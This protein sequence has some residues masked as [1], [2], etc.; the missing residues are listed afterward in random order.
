MNCWRLV[1]LHGGEPKD[2]HF[3]LKPPQWKVT[4][5]EENNGAMSLWWYT[6]LS[7]S[8]YI[9]RDDI[10]N[11]TYRW[12]RWYDAM[13]QCIP[14]YVIYFILCILHVK[15]SLILCKN[16]WYTLIHLVRRRYSDMYYPLNDTTYTC[17]F[18]MLYQLLLGNVG[19]VLAA[20]GCQQIFKSSNYKNRNIDGNRHPSGD[21]T[22]DL[23]PWGLHW[24]GICQ[25]LKLP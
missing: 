11:I 25:L 9:L 10:W 24:L 7:F 21:N 2:E 8:I 20:M 5:R 22:P 14:L 12:Y 19:R 13:I 4:C 6:S 17:C 16:D 18:T 1:V 23:A 15:S 3:R